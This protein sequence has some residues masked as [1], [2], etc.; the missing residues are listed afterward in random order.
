MTSKFESTHL[1]NGV[2]VYNTVAIGLANLDDVTAKMRPGIMRA[3]KVH[4]FLGCPDDGEAR[5]A[6]LAVN[7]RPQVGVNR[8][9]HWTAADMALRIELAAHV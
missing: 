5:Q 2:M 6:W 9:D 3:L 8:V 4:P 1:V 7:Y